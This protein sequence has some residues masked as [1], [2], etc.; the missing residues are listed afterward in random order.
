MCKYTVSTESKYIRLIRIAII[1]LSSW[2]IA[3]AA[4]AVGT[5]GSLRKS[6]QPQN[7]YQNSISA[8]GL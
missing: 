3:G 8:S 7:M 1:A 5:T 2:M 6:R 4:S